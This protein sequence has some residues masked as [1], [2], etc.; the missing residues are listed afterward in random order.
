MYQKC[1]SI[2]TTYEY[3]SI[4]VVVDLLVSFRIGGLSSTECH[5]TVARDIANAMLEDAN[6]HNGEHRSNFSRTIAQK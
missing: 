1:C 2:S 6:S 5:G 4:T 3:C